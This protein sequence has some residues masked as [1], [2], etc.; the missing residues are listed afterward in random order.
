MAFVIELDRQ[1]QR[2]RG[3]GEATHA[4]GLVP[5]IAGERQRESDD[6]H[7]AL[8]FA[9]DLLDR[10]D[11][12]RLSPAR[13]R[14]QR[15]NE[16]VRIV[17]DRQT[18]PAIADVERKIS[19]YGPLATAVGSP[20]VTVIR[21]SSSGMSG[22]HVGDRTIW[23]TWKPRSFAILVASATLLPAR[24]DARGAVRAYWIDDA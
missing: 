7:A 4:F 5:F 13:E 16:A 8:L 9:R 19:H 18:D 21:E 17:T 15:T 6:E 1:P 23:L 10:G 11:V 12:N 14:G 2:A 22:N 24:A 3:L 20:I